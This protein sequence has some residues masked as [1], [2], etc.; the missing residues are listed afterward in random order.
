M[1]RLQPKKRATKPARAT[2]ERLSRRV[3]ALLLRCLRFC[4]SQVRGGVKPIKRGPVYYVPLWLPLALALLLG[5]H[6]YWADLGAWLGRGAVELLTGAKQTELPAFFAPSVRHWSAD[7]DEWAREHELDPRL[8][9]T[10]MQIESCGHPSVISQAG[11][12]GLFQVMPFHFEAGEDMLDADTNARRGSAFLNYCAAASGQVIGLTLA[13]Y[14]GGP[15]VINLPR[16]RWS[17]ETQNYYRWGVGIYSDA[18]AGKA[19][20]ETMDQWLAAGGARLC[21]SAWAELQP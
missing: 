9:A 20:S 8:L 4:H 15:S 2:I 11:A 1:N 14:N 3:Y 19:Q 17:K 13:C 18:L 12:Q 16:E 10:V 21:D 7:I 5:T 6:V